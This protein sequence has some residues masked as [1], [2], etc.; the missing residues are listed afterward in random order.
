MT[1]LS[2]VIKIEGIP[3]AD[4]VDVVRC[5]DCIYA[6]E[7]KEREHDPDALL[8]CQNKMGTGGYVA[9]MDYCSYGEREPE[10]GDN[11]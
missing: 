1:E 4:V 8:V 6:E 2:A 10:N 5:K 9:D 7:T 11:A 3:V